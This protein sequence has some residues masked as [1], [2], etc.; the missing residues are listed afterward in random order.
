MGRKTSQ[1]EIYC[2][3]MLGFHLTPRQIIVSPARNQLLRKASMHGG[4]GVEAVS[5]SE[6]LSLCRD[7]ASMPISKSPKHCGFGTF[8]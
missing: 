2:Y 4:Q 1:S 8:I 7:G 3:I 6:A 5:L